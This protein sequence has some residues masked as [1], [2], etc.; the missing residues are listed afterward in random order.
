MSDTLINPSITK[1]CIRKKISLQDM[2]TVSIRRVEGSSDS[3]KY[4][5]IVYMVLV[6]S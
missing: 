1:H 5:W 3:L 6:D 4:N 2:E